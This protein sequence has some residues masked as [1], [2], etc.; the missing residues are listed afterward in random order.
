[1]PV[2]AEVLESIVFWAAYA[3]QFLTVA[4]SPEIQLLSRW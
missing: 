4:H 3:P 1:M 2:E